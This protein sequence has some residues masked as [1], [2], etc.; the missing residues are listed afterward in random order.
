MIK[1]KHSYRNRNRPLVVIREVFRIH[2]C[3][4]QKITDPI[5]YIITVLKC[6]KKS[7]NKPNGSLRFFDFI[8]R[9][10]SLELATKAKV[11][12]DCF[13]EAQ[14]EPMVV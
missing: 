5:M 7:N 3:G 11:C 4:S 8:C 2:N 13:K 12:K 1:L 9:N 6:L 10:L 14:L